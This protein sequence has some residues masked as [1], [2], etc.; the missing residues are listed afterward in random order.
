[1]GNKPSSSPA[2]PPPPPP[3]PPPTILPFVRPKAIDINLTVEKSKTCSGCAVAAAAGTSSSAITLTRN[4]MGQIDIPARA[5]SSKWVWDNAVGFRDDGTP[6]L[7][8]ADTETDQRCSSKC[9]YIV[10]NPAKWGKEIDLGK[11]DA[12]GNWTAENGGHVRQMFSRDLNDWQS[13]QRL[14]GRRAKSSGKRV[15]MWNPS[16]E[17]TDSGGSYAINYRNYGALTKLFLKPTL[18]FSV[19]YSGM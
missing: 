12:K 3:P 7:V 15:Y 9:G 14:A 19:N 17:L 16:D 13:D 4:L 1:M 10:A 11:I 2:P 18:P 5:S 6:Y 8:E